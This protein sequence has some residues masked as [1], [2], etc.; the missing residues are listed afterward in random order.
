MLLETYFMFNR[1]LVCFYLLFYSIYTKYQVDMRL[2]P[3]QGNAHFAIH[4]CK[5]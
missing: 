5:L 1:T 3:Y 4:N 2:E